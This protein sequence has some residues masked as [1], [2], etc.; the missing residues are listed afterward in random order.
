MSMMMF[1]KGSPSYLQ[2][3]VVKILAKNYWQ[4]LE[5][6]RGTCHFMGKILDKK[7]ANNFSHKMARI[8]SQILA[9]IFA[10]IMLILFHFFCT[11]CEFYFH[12][13]T[14]FSSICI[15]TCN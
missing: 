11:G 6:I 14:M 7:L 5:K 2:K 12:R 10:L 13:L 8:C 9:N 15:P 3:I 4:D 1:Y